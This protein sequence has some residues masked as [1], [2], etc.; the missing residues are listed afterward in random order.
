GTSMAVSGLIATNVV[1]GGVEA[2]IEDSSITTSGTEADKGRVIVDAQNTAVINAHVVN[3]VSSGDKAIGVT[4]AFNS[5]G[6][7]SQDV[8]T[9]SIDAII[10]DPA[11]ADKAFGGNAGFDATAGLSDTEVSA[12]GDVSVTAISTANLDA[13]VENSTNSAASAWT[14]AGGA[15]IGFF[16]GQNKVSSKATAF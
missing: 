14:G 9:Q 13:V 5:I 11:M 10:G 15:A 4:L 1:Q 16:L 3:L 6:W 7:A 12:K 2:L 8:L